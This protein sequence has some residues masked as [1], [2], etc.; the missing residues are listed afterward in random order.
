MRRRHWK[1]RERARGL[2]QK[3]LWQ[4]LWRAYPFLY[5]THQ[6]TVLRVVLGR[7]LRLS[8][9]CRRRVSWS[10]HQL[11]RFS[12]LA[13]KVDQKHYYAPVCAP[14]YIGT[15]GAR[16]K[17]ELCL[18]TS[19]LRYPVNEIHVSLYL[20]SAI[21]NLFVPLLEICREF[22]CEFTLFFG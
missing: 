10:M 22:Y 16:K 18:V 21:P 5:N 17:W 13:K 14:P 4:Y 8:R 9:A 12:T 11:A 20:F 7:S 1:P 3:K 2:S 6:L 15:H 19:G